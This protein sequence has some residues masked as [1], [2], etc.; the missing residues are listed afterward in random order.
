MNGQDSNAKEQE[1][2]E[3]EAR[4][5]AILDTAADAIITI[6]EHGIVEIA[7]PAVER[8]F[9]YAPSELIG[10]N[11]SV[12]MP[13]PH[14]ENHD[15]YISRYVNGGEAHVIGIGRELEGCRRDG[16]LF[17]MELA[18]S[19]VAGVDRRRFTGII[20]DITIR[21]RAEEARR[22]SEARIQAILDTAVD[23]IITID[24]HGIVEIA[25]PAVE[26]LFGY[27]PSELIGRNVSVL[28][29]SPHR[30]NHDEYISRYVN[31]GEPHVIGIGR[32]LEGRRR[33]GT[34]F[35]M[36]LALSEV[37]EGDHRRFTGIIRDI[38]IRKR[39]EE[40]LIRIDA[41]KDE[42]LANTSHELR[43]PLSG[44][45]GIGNQCSPGL[46]VHSQKISAAICR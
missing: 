29:P 32:E 10:R 24:E 12:L 6:D 18:L 42:F 21:K 25:N 2:R 27:A 13:S 35:P 8:L 14:R 15:E 37:A 19:E 5:Q 31:G 9:G 38:T 30:E 43:T 17:P 3:S 22:E 39:A 7:N 4:I 11:V 26:R 40:A 36:E 46:G 16:T 33:D 28:M 41:L 34:T 44:I 45:I 20:R 23:A 1:L